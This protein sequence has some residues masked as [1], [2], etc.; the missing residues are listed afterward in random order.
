MNDPQPVV[1]LSSSGMTPSER[2][3]A[4]RETYGRSVLNIDFEPLVDDP[5]FE[6]EVRVLPGVCVTSGWNTPYHA[7][8]HDP[9]RENDDFLFVWGDRG[10]RTR[11]LGKTVESSEGA[12][13]LTCAEKVLAEANLPMSHRTLRIAREALLPILPTAEDAVATTVPAS[14]EAFRLLD[15]YV[16]LICANGTPASPALAQAAANHICDLVALAV[17]TTAI[18]A[19]QASNRGLRAARLASIK[20]WIQGRLG[21]PLLSVRDAAAAHRVSSRYVQMLF[22][23]EQSSFSSFV[24]AERLARARR[25]LTSPALA[26]RSIASIALD[27][28]FND[29]SYF[30]RA[31]RQAYGETPS[32]ARR[33]AVAGAKP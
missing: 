20:A 1:R 15:S 16:G 17:G 21:N 30:N 7:K 33:A 4:I 23:S 14:N 28:G 18:A 24:R 2:A 25:W 5:Q 9:S 19:H 3:E 27:A 12:T 22:E 8:S 32:D 10:G 6:I 29:I 26:G 13:L 31:F 11:P